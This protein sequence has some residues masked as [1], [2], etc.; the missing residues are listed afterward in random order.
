MSD[1][2]SHSTEGKQAA[3]IVTIS[4]AARLL[5]CSVSTV[6]RRLDKGELEAVAMAGKRCVRLPA[7]ALPT[8]VQPDASQLIV[9]SDALKVQPDAS[10]LSSG[11]VLAIPQ[12]SR[13][14][15]LVAA[16]VA[17]AMSQQAQAKPVPSVADLA[18]KYLLTI[19]E[20]SQLSGA[21][22]SALEAAIRNGHLKAHKGLGRGRRLKRADLEKWAGKL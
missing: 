19:D 6:Q 8:G 4:E 5:E 1:D 3:Y 9:D 11:A 14:A 21:G 18:A 22:R 16:I 20:A 12:D 13:G 17:E 7:D 10:Q 15:A 2:A